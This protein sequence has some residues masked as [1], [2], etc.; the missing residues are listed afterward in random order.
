MHSLLRKNWYSLMVILLLTGCNII[1]PAEPVPGYIKIE[2]FTITPTP[3]LGTDSNKITDVYDFIDTKYQGSYPL[4]AQFPVI[5]SG[6]HH[7]IF[8]AGIIING[9]SNNRI[10]YPFYEPYEQTVNL[11]PGKIT[12]INP[13]IKYAEN[14]VHPWL[15]NFENNGSSLL[16]DASSQTGIILLQPGDPNNFE[17]ISGA[18]Y[19][20]ASQVYFK[21]TTDTSYILPTVN[22]PVYLEMNYKCNNSFHVGLIA[23]TTSGPVTVAVLTIN[24]KAS[25][26]KIYVELASVLNAYTDAHYF[27]IFFDATKNAGVTNAEF[28]FDNFKLLHN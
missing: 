9:I 16:K 17:G 7:M 2:R 1:N 6:N 11:E 3:E 26:N 15:E 5:G 23:M 4:P 19:L 21:L 14:V 25:W 20:D 27:K 22:I 13:V 18:V 8:Y 24:P 12:T 10:D 28:Y